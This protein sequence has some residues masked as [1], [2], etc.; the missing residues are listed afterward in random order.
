MKKLIVVPA[1][2]LAAQHLIAQVPGEVRGHIT[3]R[4]SGA[5]V[6]GARV[7]DAAGE[8]AGMSG[9]DG[10]FALRGLT[11]GRHELWITAIGFRPVHAVV[12]VENGRAAELPVALDVL[13][14][15]LPA[16]T[17]VAHA[18]SLTGNVVTVSRAEIEA[19]GRR[20]LAGVLE[21]QPGVVVSRTGGPGGP[22]TVSIRG[23]SANEVLV[24]VDGVRVNSVLTGEAD[25]SE[26]PVANVERVTILRGAQAARYGARALA[27]VIL[28]DTRRP[29]G[30]ELSATAVAG[31]WGDRDG[32]VTGGFSAPGGVEGIVTASRRMTAGNFPYDVPA[33]RGG[34][35]AI[36]END[37]AASSAMSTSLAAARGPVEWG[38]QA[39]FV[40]SARGLPGPVPAPDPTAR[41]HDGRLSGAVSARAVRGPFQWSANL[42]ADREHT[43]DQSRDSSVGPPYDDVVHATSVTAAAAGTLAGPIVALSMGAEARSIQLAATALTAAAPKAQ[44]DEGVWTQLRATRLLGTGLLVAADAGVRVDRNSLIGGVI[45]SPHVGGSLARGSLFASVS[46]GR[47]YSPPTLAD[48]YFHEGVLVRPNPSLRPEEVRGDIEGR[49]GIRDMDLGPAMGGARFTGEIALYRADVGGMIQWFPDYRFVWSPQN[50]NVHRRGWDASTALAFPAVGATLSAGVSDVAAEYA[51]PVVG[52]QVAYRPRVTAD[53]RAALTRTRFHAEITSR[54]VGDRRTTQGSPLNTLRGYWVSDVHGTVRVLTGA[55]PLDVVGGV[56]NALDRRAALL[57]DYPYPGR[58][59]SVGIRLQRASTGGS[60]VP[61]STSTT[62]H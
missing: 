57:F 46:T 56:D 15:Q 54:Y 47:S 12:A 3:A 48:Q 40:E 60:L 30:A 22:A 58:T 24:I 42:A 25:L 55:W 31:S 23:S 49:L 11:P 18:D 17:I 1:L 29:A 41:K 61:L 50:V 32:T 7:D 37:D 6:A 27:G 44:D 13:V 59:W 34:G 38:A 62:V 36:R 39:S 2:F 43:R 35:R 51:G 45:A 21:Q 26:I 33:I 10:A 16:T 53:L 14:T 9:T 4:A 20:D 52:G 19:S 5:P 8:V 28:V